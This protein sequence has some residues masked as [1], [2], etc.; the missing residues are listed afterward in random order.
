MKKILAIGLS[1]FLTVIVVLLVAP[2]FYSLDEMKPRIEQ[3]ANEK[4]RGE[5]KLGRLSFALFPVLKIGADQVELHESKGSSSA[6]FALLEKVEIRM[7]LLSLISSPRA[8]LRVAGLNL[9]YLNSEEKGDNL[10]NFLL[11]PAPEKE[12]QEI[13]KNEGSPLAGAQKELAGALNEVPGWFRDRI[14]AARFSFD[15]VNANIR[16]RMISKEFSFTKDIKKL[17]FA[18]KD[19]GFNSPVNMLST[20]EVLLE[21]DGVKVEGPFS[22][23]GELMLIP[24]QG[25]SS[26]VRVK[27]SQKLDDVAISAFG[28]LDKRQGTSL[29]GEL[30]GVIFIGKRIDA[31]I[32]T[33]AFQFGGIR[34]AGTLDFGMTDIEDATLDFKIKSEK[35][36]LA[37]LASL[38][39]LVREYKLQ[40]QSE[41]SAGVQG[42]L[43]KA[44]LD[45]M[46][47]LSGVSGTTP[48]LAKPIQD[49]KGLVEIKG[50][51]ENPKIS[52]KDFA[53]RVGRSDL[54]LTM[55]AEGLEK[56]A[57]RVD[58]TSKLLD[59]DELMGV[60]VAASG[61]PGAA[62]GGTSS[63]TQTPA[64][65]PNASL[66]DV[67]DE[68]APMIEEHL[69]N[70]MLDRISL[71][72]GINVKTI[73]V[74]GTEYTDAVIDARLA[75]RKMTIKTG[76]MGAYGGKIQANMDLG[77]NPGLLD[78]SMTATMN[79]IEMGRAL[80]AHAPEWKDD[81]TGWL[82][83]S[84][85]LSGKGLRKAQ[86]AKN[87][88]GKI[89]GSMESGRLNMPVLKLVEGLLEKLPQQARSGVDSKLGDQEFRG[90]FRTMKLNADIEGRTIKLRELNVVYDPNKAKI[91][92]LRF[93]ST[94]EMTFDKEIRFDATAFVSPELVRVGEWRGSSGLVEI[95][96]KL[97][98]TMEDPKP[99]IG[100]TTKILSERLAKGVAKRELQK[101]A[102]KAIE[103]I[104][105]RAPEPLKKTIDDLKK[106]IRF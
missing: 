83:G 30:G 95:P 79:K 4:V 10:K 78:Y 86:L 92:D 51:L 89:Q 100:Y 33:L 104:R 105:E 47:R 82:V 29:N 84:M 57:A 43:K 8:T 102:P 39:P 52:V 55:S 19:I 49:L 50:T 38:V 23:D 81:V 63:R 69:K 106:K 99:D 88:R 15:M 37:G 27:M 42:P 31:K 62:K 1:L 54:A 71:R 40:G 13:V 24:G 45:I 9:D 66:D 67:L 2:L 98:G 53:L 3:M 70:V 64:V 7:P 44:N 65:D 93:S 75:N 56:I 22:F 21:M 58:L 94:G 48:E 26:E 41:F 87:L 20:G 18:V 25:D 103:K 73:R 85:A 90:D 77:L 96:M 12:P 17:N 76:E 60:E 14:L 32:D 5:V 6:P 34:T 61:T 16:A 101:V 28:L 68:M 97:T 35:I 36:D 72:A 74:V 46:A 11:E 80:A 91:G 59:A